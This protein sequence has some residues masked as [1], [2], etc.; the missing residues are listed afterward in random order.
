MAGRDSL[1]DS[2]TQ[3]GQEMN[4]AQ[5]QFP[6]YVDRAARITCPQHPQRGPGVAAVPID[7]V[8]PERL[9]MSTTRK[10]RLGPLP[11]REHQADLCLPVAP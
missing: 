6:T 7:V 5:S 1:K 10:R 11:T 4:A 3:L 9:T 8:Q 2:A